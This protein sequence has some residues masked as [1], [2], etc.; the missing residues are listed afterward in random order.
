MISHQLLRRYPFFGFLDEVQLR[1]IAMVAEELLLESG[2]T[3]FTEG[4][5]ADAL[6]ILEDGYIELYYL[7]NESES[8]DFNGILVGG[9]CPGE[10]IAIS[11][12][13]EPHILTSTA[14]ASK[15]SRV[16]KINACA[17]L[18]LLK[19]DR[20]LAYVLT[21][22]AAKTAVERLLTTRIQLAA[23]WAKEADQVTL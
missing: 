19:T 3:L 22:Q 12:L 10:V 15:P 5:P 8:L 1:A 6:Y 17:L 18:D 16:I 7:A 13:I 20:R 9:I 2:Q 21:H 14:R 23:V 4:Q 11:S